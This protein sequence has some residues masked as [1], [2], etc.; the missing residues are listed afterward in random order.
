VLK[1][2]RSNEAKLLSRLCACNRCVPLCFRAPILETDYACAQS[3]ANRIM[4]NLLIAKSKIK[5]SAQ[6]PLPRATGITI[7]ELAMMKWKKEQLKEDGVN[8][9]LSEDSYKSRGVFFDLPLFCSWA[10]N[11]RSALPLFSHT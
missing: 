1:K 5:S 11:C 10:P 4:N 8:V 6:M 7:A 2:R 9:D 3:G